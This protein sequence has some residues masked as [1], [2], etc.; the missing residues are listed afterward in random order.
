MS[1][2]NFTFTTTVAS[3]DESPLD[4]ADEDSDSIVRHHDGHVTVELSDDLI[5]HVQYLGTQRNK[6]SG[7]THKKRDRN[8]SER[9]IHVDGLKAEAALSVA[10]EEAEL[11]E[12]IYEGSG[13]GGIDSHL[14]LNGERHSIDLKCASHAPPWIKVEAG[15]PNA[16]KC[17]AYIAAH[18]DGDT[19]E[20]YGWL[21]SEE[22]V[23]DKYKRESYA[24]YRDHE[25]YTREGGY[26]D[27]PALTHTKEQ[28]SRFSLI[29]A[30][31]D[32]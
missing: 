19:V 17:D 3:P 16:G 25:N 11:D 12:E 21:P 1:D 7:G 27:M 31:D 22:V 10:Y 30:C 4:S 15:N 24:S 23:A 14:N 26:Q 9:E 6:A 13:D 8:R 29:N 18:V 2:T 32:D 5:D 20:F 28:T